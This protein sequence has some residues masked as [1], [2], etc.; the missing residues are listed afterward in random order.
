MAVQ[1]VDN[2]EE[3]PLKH[4]TEEF[5]HIDPA[6]RAA[7]LG[8]GFD[9]R[10][11][12]LSMYGTEYKVNWPEGEV[13]SENANALALTVKHA[14]IL[15]LRYIISG[16]NIPFGG[17]YKAFRELPWG[18][19]YVKPFDGR[20][21]KRLAYKFSSDPEKYKKAALLLG[22]KPLDHSDA[23]FE[24]VFTGEYTFRFYCW[25]ADDEFPPNSQI[26]FSDNFAIGFSAEDD[27][28]VAELMI[29]A[30]S[31]AMKSVN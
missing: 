21:I 29:T 20:C 19:V 18:E 31:S 24:F 25:A 5:A 23:G 15:L 3:I 27:V 22:G 8:I 2:K 7:D 26:A 6:K 10:S 13:S 16:K 30:I 9:G 12:S 11:F 1:V 28:V 17:S 4:Y 14:K